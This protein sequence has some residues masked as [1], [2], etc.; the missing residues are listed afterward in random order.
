MT[1]SYK[2]V[3]EILTIIDSSECE[4][5]VLEMEN[6]RLV[7][8]RGGVPAREGGADRQAQA[9][10]APQAIPAV[11]EA[12]SSEAP[13]TPPAPRPDAQPARDALQGDVTEIRAP[14]VG[15]FYRRPSPNEPP[16]VE[17]GATVKAG[18]TLGLI[19]VMKLYT[20]IEAT[21]AGT[22]NS[23][24]AEDST[25]VEFNQLLFTIQPH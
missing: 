20:A 5:L 13:A 16:Y 10:P 3:A 2:E 23:I 25:L 12:Q 9:I 18:E 22:V 8:R 6:L 15:T 11:Q 7:V 21:S 1:L 24:L 17:E 14:M 4:E 19:E